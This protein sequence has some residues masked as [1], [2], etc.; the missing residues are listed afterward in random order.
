MTKYYQL[1]D[2]SHQ[3]YAAATFLNP[4]QRRDFFDNS[5]VGKLQPWIEVMLSNCRDIWERDY[6]HLAPHKKMKKRDAFEEWLYRKKEEDI[7][8]DEFRRYSIAGSAIPA[9]ERFDPIT[10]WT[11][12]DIE[13]AFPTLQRWALD[14][15]ACPATSCECERAFSSAKKL[16]TPE[17]NSLGDNIIEALECL[18]AWWNNGLIQRP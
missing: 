4:T 18:R 15:F 8:T 17:R 3:I 7:G 13:E 14:I 5:W 9:T 1:T 2:K 16:I 11:Q 12:P 10:W 6:A